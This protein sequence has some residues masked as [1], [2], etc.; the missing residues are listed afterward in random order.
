MK[1]KAFSIYDTATKV[2]NRPFYQHTKGQAIRSF[3]DLV[4]D[5]QTEIS[6]HPS[7]YA[8]FLLGTFEDDTGS[9]FSESAPEKVIT[10]LEVVEDA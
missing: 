3:T 2:F 10:G 9:L 6:K 7:D 8:L 1:L 4:N 5:D